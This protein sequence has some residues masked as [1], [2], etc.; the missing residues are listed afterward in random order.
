MRFTNSIDQ[1]AGMES[2]Y[3]MSG[4]WVEEPELL[5]LLMV[6]LFQTNL[7]AFEAQDS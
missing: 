4:Q 2:N 3:S 1:T 5:L 6:D 7:R